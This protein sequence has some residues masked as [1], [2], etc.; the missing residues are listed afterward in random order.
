LHK[1]HFLSSIIIYF[2]LTI[3]INYSF[4]NPFAM[5]DSGTGSMVS[6]YEKPHYGHATASVE[7]LLPH[8][9]HLIIIEILQM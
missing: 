2:R 6:F 5:F 1:N 8:Y 7:T 4:T 9:R 3:I